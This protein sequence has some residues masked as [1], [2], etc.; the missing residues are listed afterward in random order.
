[1]LLS[2]FGVLSSTVSSPYSGRI[3]KTAL[4]AHSALKYGQLVRFLSHAFGAPCF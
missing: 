3:F 1:M 4:Q 2:P